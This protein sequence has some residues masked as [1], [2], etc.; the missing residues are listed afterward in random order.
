MITPV[1]NKIAIV[2]D[3][4]LVRDCLERLVNTFSEYAVVLQADNGQ[5]FIQQLITK[6]LPDIVVLDIRM[7]VMDGFETLNWLRQN[8]PSMKSLVLTQ[9]N[10]Q[11][12]S[13]RSLQLGAAG[14]I[15]KIAEPVDF[16][17]ALD[18]IA[19]GKRYFSNTV[20]RQEFKNNSIDSL[21][22]RE[23]EFLQLA[24]TTA[25]DYEQ[26]ASAMN[27]SRHTVNG[28]AKQLFEKLEVN[29]REGLILFAMKHKLIEF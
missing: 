9:F 23:S 22:K 7:P 2:D 3:H 15:A 11:L 12:S 8:Y 29:S 20:L 14:Y 10:D 21:N 16:K 28:Y 27:V 13:I 19:K 5:H 26:I 17:K 24:C 25:R 1:I 18:T 4:V 6:Q